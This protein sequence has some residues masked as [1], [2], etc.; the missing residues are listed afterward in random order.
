MW[1]DSDIVSKWGDNYNAGISF[2]NRG[3]KSSKIID[4]TSVE[5]TNEAMRFDFVKSLNFSLPEK[6]ESLFFLT[7]KPISLL[8]VTNYIEN[9]DGEIEE[10]IMYLFTVNRVASEYI[11]HLSKTTKLKLVVSDIMNS[12][13]EKE[14]LITKTLENSNVNFIFVHSHAKVISL[15]M[16]SGNF[17]NLVGSMNAGSNAKIENLQIINSEKMFDFIDSN[18]KLLQKDFEIKKR[19]DTNQ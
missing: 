10:A 1:K 6:N 15:K 11:A 5:K 18:F 9:L 14:R 2:T 19:Y 13:R 3:K 4:F 8:D 7:S 16:K 12:K 17:F